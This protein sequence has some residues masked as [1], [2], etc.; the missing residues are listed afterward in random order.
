[1]TH[2]ERVA[3]EVLDAL[4]AAR[5]SGAIG[6]LAPLVE[7]PPDVAVRT[8]VFYLS[9]SVASLP[10]HPPTGLDVLALLVEAVRN[11]RPRQFFRL[12]LISHHIHAQAECRA[13]R[14]SVRAVELYDLDAE[15]LI[16]NVTVAGVGS[17]ASLSA[18][19]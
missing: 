2:C 18:V 15:K 9:L 12:P 11:Q 10:S 3:A 17:H 19:Y 14:I 13:G 1:M 16:I 6:L 8:G 5:D 4:T 7:A